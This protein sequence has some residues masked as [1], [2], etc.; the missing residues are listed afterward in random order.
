MIKKTLMT[1][2]AF[3]MRVLFLTYQKLDFEQD[4]NWIGSGGCFLQHTRFVEP[5]VVPSHLI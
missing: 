4:A 3:E 5:I 2:R 1:L